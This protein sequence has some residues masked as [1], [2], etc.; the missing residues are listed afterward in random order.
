MRC[1]IRKT[2][3][4]IAA[5]WVLGTSPAPV[6]AQ[7]PTVPP[8]AAAQAIAPQAVASPAATPTFIARPYDGLTAGAEAYLNAEANR[9]QD[10]ARQ[11]YHVEQLTW[12]IGLPN[13]SNGAVFYRDPASL[14]SWYAYGRPSGAAYGRRLG[15]PS[16]DV[17]E[18]WPRVPGD[19]FG[20]PD[21]APIRQPIGHISTQTGPNRWEYHPL[22][23]EDLVPAA[24]T[25]A[26]A[27][28]A[29]QPAATLPSAAPPGARVVPPPPQ[30]ARDNPAAGGPRAF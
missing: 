25:P 21:P 4:L 26:T 8:V 1:F 3:C 11:L 22:Y 17:F 29:F 19:I 5:C 7:Q 24:A 28:Q 13:R 20:Y 16:A 30:P 27:S 10:I 2:L 23:A 12:S 6:G 9:R 14:D 18:P 15:W